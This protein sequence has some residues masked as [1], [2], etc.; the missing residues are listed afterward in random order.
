M[1][2]IFPT[3]FR[4]TTLINQLKRGTFPLS[5]ATSTATV[6]TS[7]P[8]RLNYTPIETD[9]KIEIGHKM[10]QVIEK[11]RLK[12]LIKQST[13][14]EYAQRFRTNKRL[15]IACSTPQFNHYAGQHYKN[16]SPQQHLASYGWR[17]RGSA[18]KYFTVNPI[19]AHPSLIDPTRHRNEQ[20]ECID[21]SDLHTLNPILA[22]LLKLNMKISRPTYI[23]YLSI[24]AILQRR[25]HNLLVAETGGGKT[26]AYLLPM[27]EVCVRTRR[28]LNDIEI[29]RTHK[30]PIGVIVVPTRELAY[31]VYEMARSL[32]DNVEQLEKQ[33]TSRSPY[34]TEYLGYLKELNVVIDLH[35]NQIK[36]KERIGKVAVNSIR[37]QKEET[38]ENVDT[39]A[40]EKPIDI[41]I[42]LPGQLE[43][44]QRGNYFNGVFV[45]QVVLDEADTLL[46]D[47]YTLINLG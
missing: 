21:F 1:L 11:H 32:L 22:E 47:R 23:Q 2:K 27:L 35:P 29:T 26:L 24:G 34:Q 28:F 45:R 5:L 37:D 7:S 30:Q 39:K 12:H 40:V 14:E 9:H 10:T 31:Q 6:H 4:Q 20:D 46:D 41:L 44:R 43:K 16:F 17:N 3:R 42:T 38:K 33:R 18:G 13:S 8:R 25:S 36:A 19:N 15:L